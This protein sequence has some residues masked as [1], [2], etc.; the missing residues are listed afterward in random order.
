MASRYG[1]EEFA[2]ILPDTDL[3]G[4]IREGVANLT[5]VGRTLEPR[6]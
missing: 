5:A 2:M 3:A 6:T 4:A 1:G